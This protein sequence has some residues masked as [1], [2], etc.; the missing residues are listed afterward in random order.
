[1]RIK[2]FIFVLIWLI[3]IASVFSISRYA[4]PLPM[5]IYWV[6]FGLFIFTIWFLKFN[7]RLILLFAFG[8]FILA[9]LADIFGMDFIAEQIIRISLL[10]WLIGFGQS[11]F[12]YSFKKNK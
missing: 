11:A 1:M 7:S 8:L 3:G 12:E 4:D 10:G 5:L 2:F 9:G 6:W